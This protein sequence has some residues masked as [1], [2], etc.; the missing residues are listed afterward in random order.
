MKLIKILGLTLFS[1]FPVSAFPYYMGFE[2]V[3]ETQDT[4]FEVFKSYKGTFISY[5]DSPWIIRPNSSIDLLKGTGVLRNDN[6]SFQVSYKCGTHQ[7]TFAI[8]SLTVNTK[9]PKLTF[10]LV[11][12]DPQITAQASPIVPIHYFEHARLKIVI[13]NR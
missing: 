9:P 13:S 12:A 10:T 4:C 1:L 5:S 11:N 7:L 8:D 6:P 2:I 3:N